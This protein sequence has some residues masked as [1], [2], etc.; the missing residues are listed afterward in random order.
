MAL[1]KLSSSIETVQNF[2]DGK[3]VPARGAQVDVWTPYQGRVIGKYQETTASELDSI[4]ALAQRGFDT[5]SAVP[6]KERTQVMFRFREIL[7]RDAEALSHVIASES[8]KLPAEALAG[9]MKGVEVLEFATAIQNLDRGGK[10]EVSRGVW[11]ETQRVPLGVVVGITPFNFPA[12]VPMWMIPIALTLGNAFVWKPS[13]KTPLTSQR[14]AAALKEAGLPDGAFTVV[15]GGRATVEQLCQHP[16]VQ[17]VGFV[18]SSPVAKAV[19]ERATLAGKRALCLG[20]AKNHIILMPDA[21][22][23]V[24]AQGIVASFTGCAGQRC[25]A[26]SVLVAV[27]PSAA[28]TQRVLQGIVERSSKITLGQ[29]MGAIITQASLQKLEGAI[30]RAGKTGAKL[31]LDGRRA[32]KPVGYE[33]GYWLGP[34]VLDGVQPGS[35]AATDELFGPL[36]SV[37]HAKSMSEALAMAGQSEYGN[38]LSVFTQS[39]AVADEVARRARAGM[40]GINIG[41]PVPR[42]PFSFGGFLSSRFGYGD[43][44]G[45][46]GIDFWSNTRKVTTKWA[47]QKD[48]NWMS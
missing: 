45:Q 26:A 42:E 23:E 27:D 25:M 41:V 7:L 34:T 20:G 17:A 33:S 36:L 19:Y 14:I 31:A 6:I 29:D 24:A 4:L 48:R 1:I 5:W 9:L 21:D 35:E 43:I 30:D 32:A 10:M 8:G 28:S 13:E 47:L 18:G 2:V 44:T 46:G 39:G 37:M 40:V 11:C 38:A 12:M 15:Q 16:I 3:F 22:P